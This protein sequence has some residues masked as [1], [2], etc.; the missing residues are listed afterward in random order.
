VCGLCVTLVYRVVCE[1]DTPVY[2]VVCEI[3]TPVYRVV[4]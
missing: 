2:R 1:I 3:D 4:R